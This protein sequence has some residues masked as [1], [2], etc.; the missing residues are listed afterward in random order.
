MGWLEARWQRIVRLKPRLQAPGK[1]SYMLC[2][3]TTWNPTMMEVK[4]S[5]RSLDQLQR[6]QRTHCDCAL[7]SDILTMSS[8]KSNRHWS[9]SWIIL[10]T[11]LRNSS[12]RQP[13]RSQ[14]VR[15][16]LYYGMEH[17]NL[18]PIWSTLSGEA[19]KIHVYDSFEAANADDVLPKSML[20]KE[21]FV[22]SIK[23]FVQTSI[24]YV[25]PDRFKPEHSELRL[26][27]NVR[28]K[29]QLWQKR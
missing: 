3:V 5:K 4:K 6:R 14:I 19:N 21:H 26:W 2:S 9:R 16:S 13:S 12:K 27:P 7:G 23:K 1:Q 28:T 18:D 24:I 20:D 25:F 22:E 10:K 17:I 29:K 11:L 8:R 15:T